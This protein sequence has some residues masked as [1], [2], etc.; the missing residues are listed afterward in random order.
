MVSVRCPSGIVDCFA[1]TTRL[2]CS[3]ASMLYDAL[4]RA[5]NAVSLFP[6]R[7]DVEKAAFLE[8]RGYLVRC[9]VTADDH[10]FLC[11]DIGA[12]ER[13]R[14]PAAHVTD[15][16]GF[17]DD[18]PFYFRATTLGLK[19]TARDRRCASTTSGRSRVM[20]YSRSA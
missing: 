1:G 4:L 8:Q 5:G 3:M 7:Q 17:A 13:G 12:E 18:A 9:D 16:L 2:A 11:T 15:A 19:D 20:A 6:R 14:I 10:V